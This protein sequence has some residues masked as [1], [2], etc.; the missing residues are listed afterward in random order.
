MGV[1]INSEDIEKDNDEDT[2]KNEEN[3]D[4]GKYTRTTNSVLS[5]V[6]K[7]PQATLW[8]PAASRVPVSK[9]TRRHSM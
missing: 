6:R 1:M 8:S 2:D 3:W 7:K 4:E 9:K 5:A